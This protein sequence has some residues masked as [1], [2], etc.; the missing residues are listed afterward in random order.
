MEQEHIL[1]HLHCTH[2]GQQLIF[3]LNLPV[4]K[5]LRRAQP[6]LCGVKIIIEGLS[7]LKINAERASM[8]PF[9]RKQSGALRLWTV[10]DVFRTAFPMILGQKPSVGA[11]SHIK[12]MYQNDNF[13]SENRKVT[14][15]LPIFSLKND[16]QLCVV[17]QNQALSALTQPT[18]HID[19]S[20]LVLR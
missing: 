1:I 2:E 14:L 7:C 5:Y 9:C 15:A 12:I 20:A 11:V 4:A 13:G 8:A 17:V 3:A 16:I 10:L 6:L 18:S 19:P